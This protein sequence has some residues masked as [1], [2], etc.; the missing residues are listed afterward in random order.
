MIN[1]IRLNNITCFKDTKIFDNLPQLVTIYGPDGSGKSSII[2]AIKLA[3]TGKDDNRSPKMMVNKT[4]VNATVSIEIG[5]KERTY[6]MDRTFTSD[7]KSVS[8]G[9][10][11]QKLASALGTTRAAMELLVDSWTILRKSETEL[12]STI[13]KALNPSMTKDELV[14]SLLAKVPSEE[15][16]IC[17]NIIDSFSMKTS[18]DM[19]TALVKKLNTELKTTASEIAADT[20]AKEEIDEKLSRTK[21]LNIAKVRLAKE[22]AEKLA[23]IRTIQGE[24]DSLETRIRDKLAPDLQAKKEKSLASVRADIEPILKEIS[25]KELEIDGVKRQMN[26][27]PEEYTIDG[28]TL[29]CKWFGKCELDPDI[30]LEMHE[31]NRIANTEKK[32]RLQL[33]LET[34]TEEMGTLNAK[35][36]AAKLTNASADSAKADLDRVEADIKSVTDQITTRKDTIA[37]LN[38]ELPE[39]QG[40]VGATLMTMAEEVETWTAESNRLTSNIMR[41]NS[42]INPIK[43]MLKGMEEIKDAASSTKTAAFRKTFLE[44]VTRIYG[45]GVEYGDKGIIING[46]SHIEMSMS[47][48]QRIGIA[49]QYALALTTGIKIMLIDNMNIITDYSDIAP[50]LEMALEDGIQIFMLS[51]LDTVLSSIVKH[52][53]MKQIILD[54]VN[55][56]VPVQ[57]TEQAWT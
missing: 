45:D 48:Q 57:A 26:A 44:A 40:D 49:M 29:P 14:T 46:L 7:N 19:I 4:T 39:D 42:L 30:I 53:K 11:P 51:S 27:I 52:D 47:Q 37:R 28:T 31:K 5:L 18:N 22:R 21:E 10:S 20:K 36:T 16:P 3:L 2:S 15:T 6:I 56:K 25:R 24:I 17:K 55:H 8:G 38:K 23:V 32:S 41:L 33:Q 35:L 34:L 1:K 50:V 54:P 12:A 13:E 9:L 43:N